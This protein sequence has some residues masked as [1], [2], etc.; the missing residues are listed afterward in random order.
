MSLQSIPGV[1]P[2]LPPL[3]NI[4]NV[5]V[6]IAGTADTEINEKLVGSIAALAQIDLICT[7]VAAGAAGY[8]TLSYD[9]G[10]SL[11]RLQQPVTP[12]VG[13]RLTFNFP[14]YMLTGSPGSASSSTAGRFRLTPSVNVGTWWCTVSGVYVPIQVPLAF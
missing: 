6:S 8:W 1:S 3:R 12:V 5:G 10:T 14:A 13:A 2:V 4:S 9:G 11:A 7:A